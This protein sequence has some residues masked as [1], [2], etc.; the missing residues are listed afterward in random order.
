MGSLERFLSIYIEHTAGLFPLWLAPVQVAL[1]PV[2]ETH[3]GYAAEIAAQLKKEGMRVVILPHT[4][5]LGKRIREGETQKI[6]YL[7]VV[8]D[9]E[10]EAA[11]VAVR[12]VKTK[13]QVVI[14]V[15]EFTEKLKEDIEQ[16]KLE[17]SIG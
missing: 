9:K 6:P 14:S 10:M 8:G 3:E 7:L 16:R 12:N 5:S 2:A 1:I 17:A 11:S 13:K 15:K 4:D